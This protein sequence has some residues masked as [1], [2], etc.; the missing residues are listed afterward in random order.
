[1][2]ARVF[3][4]V[5]NEEKKHRDVDVDL[6]A[7]LDIA[8]PLVG[9]LDPL[10]YSIFIEH[11]AKG[12]SFPDPEILQSAKLA[13]SQ[14]SDL[15]L[16]SHCRRAGLYTGLLNRNLFSKNA[17]SLSIR[18]ISRPTQT[19]REQ[20]APQL[21][22]PSS[23][24]T[25]RITQPTRTLIEDYAIPDMQ[26]PSKDLEWAFQFEC[27]QMMQPQEYSPYSMDPFD[28][29]CLSHAPPAWLSMY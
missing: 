21:S 15:D 5:R 7:F 6:K 22:S 29:G 28:P 25:S 4:V 8:A 19:V 20:S 2:L 23:S 24:S 27:G 12:L 18:T 26:Y 1:M 11:K 17:E 14:I 10:S 16:V 9:A 13:A 3:T